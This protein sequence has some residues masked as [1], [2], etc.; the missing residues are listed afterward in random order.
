MRC[1]EC[2]RILVSNL[3]HNVVAP[4]I[5]WGQIKAQF[6]LFQTHNVCTFSSSCIFQSVVCFSSALKECFDILVLSIEYLVYIVFIYCGLL[7]VVSLVCW[8]CW[9]VLHINN[10]LLG[11]FGP[12]K[13]ITMMAIMLTW[14][15][16]LQRWWTNFNQDTSDTQWQIYNW[17]YKFKHWSI[18]Q[19]QRS[20][21]AC[22]VIWEVYIPTNASKA[23]LNWSQS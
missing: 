19:R 17:D 15:Q 23:M 18:R 9:G 5:F 8:K 21:T 14:T 20:L 7:K 6:T 16:N 2:V 3:S 12:S 22:I 10:L 4:Q 1:L 13:T 11:H